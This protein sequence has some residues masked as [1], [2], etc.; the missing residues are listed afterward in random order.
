MTLKGFLDQVKKITEA[1]RKVDVNKA[2]DQ[3]GDFI[4]LFSDLTGPTKATAKKSSKKA[5]PDATFEDLDREMQELNRACQEVQNAPATG[6]KVGAKKVGAFDPATIL[7]IIQT[8]QAFVE[9]IRRRK[10]GTD[11]QA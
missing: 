2:L 10:A 9:L 5:K 3:L 1:V 7:L 11:Q 8:V 4:Q 6:G